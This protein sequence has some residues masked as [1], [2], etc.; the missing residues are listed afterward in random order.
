MQHRTVTTLKELRIGD[1][2]HFPGKDEKYQVTYQSRTQTGI[3]QPNGK[4]GLVN[5]Y[6]S[7]KPNTK[8]VVFLRHTRPVPGEQ[9]LFMDLYPGEAFHLPDD[10]ISEY[11]KTETGVFNAS[12]HASS[13]RLSG[14]DKVVFVRS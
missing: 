1:V 6:D 11:V 5:K 2:F 13:L 8:N 9:C 7:L 14:T 10:I 12:G 3:N 4:G